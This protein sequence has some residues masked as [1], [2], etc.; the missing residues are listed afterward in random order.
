VALA[1]LVV[2]TKA[3]AFH[4]EPR[5][6]KALKAPLVT[7]YEP[8][9]AANTQ[10]RGF[11]ALPACY[12]AKRMD[13]LCGF[14]S[15]NALA[16]YGKASGKSRP[17]GDFKIDI[18]AKGLNAGCEGQ[19]LCGIVRVRATTHRCDQGP[20][21][22]ADLDFTGSSP[23]AC[24][25]VVSGVCIVS[26]TINSEVLGTLVVGDRTGFEVYGFG[27]KR[28]SGPNPPSGY[29]FTSGGLTP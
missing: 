7:A 18:S 6:A 29:S 11:P 4:D 16:G 19:T 20:C 21:T 22:V 13:E 28:V 24:C 27:L 23:T 8:C 3:A 12:P 15:S 17:N 10:T 25:S 1:A 9:T 5:R 26:T 14:V 2:T